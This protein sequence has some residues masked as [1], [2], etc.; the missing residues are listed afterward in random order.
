[1]I[2]VFIF[3]SRTRPATKVK[4]AQRKAHVVAKQHPVE[5]NP[6]VQFYYPMSKTPWNNSLR[7]V[8]L[9][10]ADAKYYIGIEILSD[11]KVAFKKFLKTKA[12]QMA[13]LEFNSS[14]LT[15]GKKFVS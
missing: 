5:K 13:V 4:V 12:S 9:I 8:W 3:N 11:N 2:T 7:S 6:L 10:S 15:N 14:S 1:M